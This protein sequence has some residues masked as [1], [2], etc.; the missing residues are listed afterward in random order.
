MAP[1]KGRSM[2]CPSREAESDESTRPYAV[3]CRAPALNGGSQAMHCRW[4][5][6]ARPET[7]MQSDSRTG[8]WRRHSFASS[9]RPKAG[10]Q[11][12]G[13]AQKYCRLHCRALWTFDWR[14]CLSTLA[15]RRSCCLQVAGLRGHSDVHAY[16]ESL[17]SGAPERHSSRTAQRTGR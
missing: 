1:A 12:E 16:R 15:E 3:M 10:E 6:G 14:Y 7:S 8:I 11:A 17:F 13:T 9:P 4:V 5:V 2:P